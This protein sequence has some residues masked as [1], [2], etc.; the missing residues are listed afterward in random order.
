[1]RGSRPPALASSPTE[2]AAVSLSGRATRHPTE[3]R[4]L[5]DD[6]DGGGDEDDRLHP[7]RAVES[8]ESGKAR[9]QEGHGALQA[10]PRDQRSFR[11]AQAG[12]EQ[13]ERDD[14]RPGE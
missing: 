2:S 12:A 13:A 9:Q 7:V 14:E 10:A 1:M 8:F 6:A 4:S 11:S 5:H 3:S